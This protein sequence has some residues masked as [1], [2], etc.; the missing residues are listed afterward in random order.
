ME[1]LGLE[2]S[3]VEFLH[4]LPLVGE[5]LPGGVVDSEGMS[6]GSITEAREERARWIS[7]GTVSLNCEHV[8]LKGKIMRVGCI[9]SSS[10][11][12]AQ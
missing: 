11:G 6:Q 7:F 9:G 2:P 5:F 1:T 3:Q 12:L 8:L 4:P 10:P